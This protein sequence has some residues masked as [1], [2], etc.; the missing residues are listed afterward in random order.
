MVQNESRIAGAAYGWALVLGGLVLMTIVPSIVIEVGPMESYVKDAAD[1]AC[2]T[3]DLVEYKLSGLGNPVAIC[4]RWSPMVVGSV[5]LSIS[6]GL[7]A[8]VDGIFTLV[9]A[10]R[11]H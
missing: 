5:S 9:A 11:R 7:I 3:D 4:Q 8:I 1:N 2:G 6:V 10:D